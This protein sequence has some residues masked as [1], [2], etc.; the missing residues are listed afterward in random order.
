MKMAKMKVVGAALLVGA[1]FAGCSK[2][3][4]DEAVITVNGEKLLRSQVEADTEAIMKFQGDKI[5]EDQRD[6]FKSRV[7]NQ[8]AQGFIV[9][10][11]LVAKAKAAGFQ[12]ADADRKAREDE[13]MKSAAGM[14]DAPKSLDEFFAKHPLGTERAKREF[15]NG[16]LIDMLF[17]AE[18]AKSPVDHT[19]KAREIIAGIVSNNLVAAASETNALARITALKATLDATPEAE[20][21]AKFGELAEA[22]SDCPSGKRAKGDLG[23]FSRE[24]MV[25]EFSDAAFAAEVGTIVGPVKT[26][27]GYHLILTTKKTPAVEAKDGEAAKPEKVQ[28]S[29]ILAKISTTQPVPK[30]EEVIK[31]LK[32]RSDREFVGKYVENAV[33]EANITAVDEF[34]S[35]LPPPEEPV[36]EE[37]SAEPVETPA[38]K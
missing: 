36:E 26:Q 1:L 16:I 8:V 6:Y 10:N 2:S 4:T 7:R 28:A 9:E 21:A 35:L 32:G 12:V 37:N 17:K 5:P 14:P 38:E 20:K 33:K 27:F 13:F 18:L 30:E 34:K 31:F 24:M 15:E 19:E 25:K 22:N 3:T 11:L 29:H 23:E